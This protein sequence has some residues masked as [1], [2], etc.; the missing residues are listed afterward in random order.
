MKNQT[1][2]YGSY[3][4]FDVLE[5]FLQSAAPEISSCQ[6]MSR[7][8]LLVLKKFRYVLN[9]HGLQLLIIDYKIEIHTGLYAH[10]RPLYN[11]AYILRHLQSDRLLQWLWHHWAALP[12]KE[13]FPVL[14]TDSAH[15][16]AICRILPFLIVIYA[17]CPNLL[18]SFMDSE[19]T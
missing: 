12:D 7:G 3:L 6:S 2:Q 8:K 16:P 9:I 18:S 19:N 10:S 11:P 13:Q 1:S 4:I 14:H 15:P 17:S 5:S